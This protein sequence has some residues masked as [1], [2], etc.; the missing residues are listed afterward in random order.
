M[1][2]LVLLAES[3]VLETVLGDDSL[4]AA[5]ALARS[6]SACRIFSHSSGSPVKSPVIG[7]IP[8]CWMCRRLKGSVIVLLV[9]GRLI[10]LSVGR[11]LDVYEY[12]A[13]DLMVLPVMEKPESISESMSAFPLSA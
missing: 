5:A 4:A 8:M 1:K 2:W 10:L 6:S 9:T 3:S 12:V 7:S 11:R 13:S